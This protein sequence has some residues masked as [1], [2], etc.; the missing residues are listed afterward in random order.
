[1]SKI[2]SN[3]NYNH[4]DYLRLTI[5]EG[6]FLVMLDSPVKW[7]SGDKDD[8]IERHKEC[9]LVLSAEELLDYLKLTLT[10]SEGGFKERSVCW[11]K[12]RNIWY[13]DGVCTIK[14]DG[15]DEPE[16][17]IQILS[18]KDSFDE[19]LKSVVRSYMRLG[20]DS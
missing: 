8:E 7:W 19:S 15:Y 4:L 3:I 17:I 14:A 9:R 12:F 16:H 1:M 2:V 5:P 13:A 18:S 6:G 20:Y 11:W 10:T